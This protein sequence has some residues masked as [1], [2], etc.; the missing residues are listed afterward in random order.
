MSETVAMGS[1]VHHDDCAGHP[2]PMTRVVSVPLEPFRFLVIGC[3]GLAVMGM[4][5]PFP[6]FPPCPL[7][8]ATGVPCPLCGM[9]R[10]VRSLLRLDL[11][12]SLRFQP[13]GI[14]AAVAGAAILVMW[15]VP[16]TRVV[17]TV[18]VPLMAIVAVGLGSWVYNVGFNPTF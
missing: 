7:L 3:L 17:R 1:V 2:A 5:A 6:V 16:R 9:T 8:T 12:A 18:R 11:G 4:L 15:A 14:L 13:F 10:S